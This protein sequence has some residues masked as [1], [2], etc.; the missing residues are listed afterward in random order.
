MKITDIRIE[1]VKARAD[2]AWYNWEDRFVRPLDVFPEF[3][4]AGVDQGRQES[5]G[6]LGVEQIYLSIVTDDGVT[7]IHGP[8]DRLTAFIVATELKPFLLGRDP[9]AVETLWEQMARLSYGGRGGVWWSAVGAVDIALWDLRG[10]AA[11]KPVYEL[12]GGA[13][14]QRIPASASFMGFSQKPDLVRERAAKFRDAGFTRQKWFFRHGPG[15][16]AEGRDLNLALVRTLRETLG[17]DYLLG[18]DAWTAWDLPYAT[19]ICR[20]LQPFSVAWLEEPLPVNRLADH[21]RLKRETGIPLSCGEHLFTLH[22]AQPWLDAGIL[23]ILQIDIGWTGGITEGLRVAAAAAEAGV[24]VVPHGGSL[25][26]SLHVLAAQP[27]E[28]CPFASHVVYMTE[29]EL[30]PLKNPPRL[31]GGAFTLPAGP[32]MGMAFDE[33]RIQA[34]EELPWAQNL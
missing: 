5:V 32:G 31:E 28:L 21:A 20:A 34:R 23:D 19:A 2:G 27:P 30:L 10:K 11:D 24:K 1:R 17:P 14:R 16:G 13:R 15:S 12:L 25:P 6:P 26:S 29:R 4:R 22:E 8:T 3:A 18:F 9:L 33:S 7:G